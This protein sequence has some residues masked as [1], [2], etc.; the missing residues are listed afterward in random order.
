[1][2][3]LPMTAL[4]MQSTSETLQRVLALVAGAPDRLGAILDEHVDAFFAFTA[5]RRILAANAAAE[6]F[7]GYGR[8]ELDG[9]LTDDLV[10]ERLRRPDAP[11]PIATRDLTGVELPGLRR[12]GVEIPAV[13]TF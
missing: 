13:W 8:H 5:G 6:R 2:G 9:R 10:P 12:D 3:T 1:M 11:P 4:S 7:F